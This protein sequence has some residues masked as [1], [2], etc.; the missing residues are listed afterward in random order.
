MKR[1]SLAFIFHQRQIRTSSEQLAYAITF[2]RQYLTGRR[3]W[4]KINDWA[5]RDWGFSDSARRNWSE[6]GETINDGDILLRRRLPILSYGCF[7]WEKDPSDRKSTTSTIQIRRILSRWNS[8][9]FVSSDLCLFVCTLRQRFRLD[10]L[11]TYAMNDSTV[12]CSVMSVVR[13]FLVPSVRISQPYLSHPS[14]TITP[15]F[16]FL[17]PT[18]WGQSWG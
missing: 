14:I 8:M 6:G 7:L 16:C 5:N 12:E 2:S 15:H 11:R 18:W 3:I 13:T 1:L 17:L 10:Y 9:D 4:Y